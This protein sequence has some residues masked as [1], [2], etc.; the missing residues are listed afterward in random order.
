MG[1]WIDENRSHETEGGVSRQILD[2]AGY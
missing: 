1:D 2:T